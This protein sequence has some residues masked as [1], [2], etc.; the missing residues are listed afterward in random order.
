[1]VQGSYSLEGL[2]GVLA[3]G[4]TSR[5]NALKQPIEAEGGTLEQAYFTFGSD[6]YVFICDLPD[7]M[8]MAA[9]TMAAAAT[10]M[11][12][13]KTTVLLTPEE[14]DAATKKVVSYRAPGQ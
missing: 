9:L 2:K 10:G 4:G 8:T 13:P 1:M 5:I 14:V 3:E 11:V 6:D 7:N 12:K